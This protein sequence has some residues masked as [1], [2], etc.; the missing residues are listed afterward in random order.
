MYLCGYRLNSSST[1]CLRKL[2][3]QFKENFIFVGGGT[4]QKE[5]AIAAHTAGKTSFDEN[6]LLL[7]KRQHITHVMM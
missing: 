4:G 6:A 2:G 5:I 3:E 7:L 1:T